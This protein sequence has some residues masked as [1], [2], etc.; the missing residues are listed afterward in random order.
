MKVRR[1][2]G[3][4]RVRCQAAGAREERGGGVIWWTC[5]EDAGQRRATPLH[6]E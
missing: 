3:T 6:F 5:E 4:L 1:A 2:E